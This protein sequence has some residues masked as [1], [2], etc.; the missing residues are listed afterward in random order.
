MKKKFILALVV[1]SFFLAGALLYNYEEWFV[2]PALIKEKR[3][4]LLNRIKDPD[5]AN[6]KDE[7]LTSAEW[8]CGRFNSKNG[9]GGY[10][11]FESFIVADSSRVYIE[12]GNLMD[13]GIEK[14]HEEVMESIRLENDALDTVIK[15]KKHLPDVI[16]SQHEIQRRVDKVVFQKRWDK[17]CTK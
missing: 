2:K 16:L 3:G 9:Y 4:Y 7:R 14:T 11:G 5:S 10:T 8:L 17:H 6:F 1:L 12:S 15:M 13:S